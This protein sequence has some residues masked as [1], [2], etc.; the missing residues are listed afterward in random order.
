MGIF[1]GCLLASD[2]D[3]TLVVDN[4][5][6]LRNK[7]KI[8]FFMREGGCFSL[9]TGRNIGAL[10]TVFKYIDKVSPS[11]LANGCLIYDY[12]N[13]KILHQVFLTEKDCYCAKKVLE[14][15]DDTGIECHCGEE[16]YILNNTHNVEDHL[17]YEGFSANEADFEFIISKPCNK[18]VMFPETPEKYQEIEKELRNGKFN[19]DIIN[20]TTT[21]DGIRRDLIEVIPKGSS[22]A[23]QLLKLCEILNIKKGC[24]YAIGDYYNDVAMLKSADISAT[25]AGAPEDVSVYATVK[26]G[27][28]TDGAV[29]D[30]IDYLTNERMKANGCSN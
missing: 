2:I 29:A 10:G 19:A 5:V 27:P 18:I 16:V 6:P 24:L 4:K 13:K 30:F 12:D 20:T 11:V 28:A 17:R 14:M 1:D 8:E 15:F 25:P 9:A 7:E 22:K 21:I 3:D 26:V 23:S